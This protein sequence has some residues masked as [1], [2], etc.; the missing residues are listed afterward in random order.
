MRETSAR[1]LKLLGLLHTRREWSGVELAERLGVTT[2]TLRRDIDKLRGLDYPIGVGMGPGG[3]YR[4]GPGAT[5]PPLLLDDEEAVG[6]AVGLRTATASGVAGVG[7]AALRALVKLEQVLPNRLRHRVAAIR[8]S[9]VDTP[10]PTVDP[11]E[12]T[13]VATACRDRQCLRFDYRGHSGVDSVRVVEPHELVT[14][15][16]R[17]YL[18]AWDRDRADWRTFRVDRMRCRIPTGPRFSPREV[19]GGDAAEFVAG[20]VERAWPHRAT[21]RLSTSADSEIALRATSYGRLEP[22]DE[23]TCLLHFGADTPHSL[24]FLLGALDVDFEVVAPGE[25][26]EELLRL[27]SRF[28]RAARLTRT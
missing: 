4:L 17:W 20:G 16:R 11:A 26:A 3:G 8:I 22:V 14:W 19:P 18:V 9:T 7:D 23:H 15:G 12:L 13:S 5:M 2:R 1:L 27:A 10:G 28:Q 25:L 24:A 6:L 21:V